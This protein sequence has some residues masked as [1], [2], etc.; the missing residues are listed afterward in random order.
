[1]SISVGAFGRSRALIPVSKIRIAEDDHGP[2]AVV[3]FS[4][5]HLRNAPSVDDDELTPARE[6]EIAAYYP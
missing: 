1:M 5:E 3:P 4:E 6:D 2:Y